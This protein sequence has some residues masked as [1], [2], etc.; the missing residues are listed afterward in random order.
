MNSCMVLMT[1]K[2]LMKRVVIVSYRVVFISCK[3]PK[4]GSYTSK[5]AETKIARTPS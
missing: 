1:T 5:H 2:F 4:A 3:R